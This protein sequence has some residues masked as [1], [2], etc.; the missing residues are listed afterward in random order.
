M[1]DMQFFRHL[2]ILSFAAVLPL[3]Q[4]RMGG[5]LVQPPAADIVHGRDFGSRFCA[6]LLCM[7]RKF[8]LVRGGQICSI[9]SDV[10]ASVIL[11]SK[12]SQ[13]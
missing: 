13:T 4:T 11:F 7:H 3:P 5:I 9:G 8:V 6:E 12:E 10:S 1:H 2:H